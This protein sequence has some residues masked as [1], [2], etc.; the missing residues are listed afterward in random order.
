[1]PAPPT[2]DGTL[3]IAEGIETATAAMQM[4]GIPCWSTLS[5][6]NMRK[7]GT[8]LGAN[9]VMLDIIK[10]LI[11]FSDKGKVGED[12][13]EELR[14]LATAAGISAEVRLPRG[15]DDFADDLAKGL[16]PMDGGSEPE[17][18]LLAP[19]ISFND[20]DAKASE[21]TQDSS[22]QNISD[23][24]RSMA[25]ARL[26][27][28]QVG[29]LIETIRTRTRLPKDDIKQQLK[30]ERRK[31]GIGAKSAGMER[32]A[33]WWKKLVC[34]ESGEPKPILMNIAIALREDPAWSGVLAFNEFTGWITLRRPPPWVLWADKA[35]FRERPWTDADGRQA[36]MWVQH[37]G[38]H[39]GSKDVPDYALSSATEAW[40]KTGTYGLFLRV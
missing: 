2:L 7:L 19:A 11:I 40:Y 21:L 30:E 32:A 39:A 20:V 24:L 26:E 36:T 14:A 8:W 13:A 9:S 4:T 15:D 16:L 25:Q 5:A 6:G 18:L 27:P 22:P 17:I 35:A 3:G 12:A 29:K 10:R 31:L 38:I 1:M 28:A 34:W 33:S 23:V 37:V